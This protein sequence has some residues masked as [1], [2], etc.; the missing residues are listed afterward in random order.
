M[1][2][3]SIFTAFYLCKVCVFIVFF[4]LMK[5]TPLAYW[6]SGHD[7]LKTLSQAVFFSDLFAIILDSYFE[8]TICCYYNLIFEIDPNLIDVLKEEKDL[9]S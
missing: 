8:F 2:S 1:G 5:L 7:K 4:L 9:Y 6:K 3:I